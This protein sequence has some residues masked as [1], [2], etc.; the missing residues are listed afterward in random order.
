[1]TARSSPQTHVLRHAAQC[2]R[3]PAKGDAKRGLARTQGGHSALHMADRG[4][5]QAPLQ[6]ASLEERRATTVADTTPVIEAQLSATDGAGGAAGPK[7]LPETLDQ[8]FQRRAHG[9]GGS[10]RRDSRR[11]TAP[12]DLRPGRTG[13]AETCVAGHF[14]LRNT[15]ITRPATFTSGL[16]I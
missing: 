1:M 7:T 8:G 9:A 11:L 5:S 4:R 2:N 13:Y 12:P 14:I 3:S 6:P 16:R 10:G 15:P